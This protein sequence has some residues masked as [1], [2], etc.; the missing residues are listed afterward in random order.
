[1]VDGTVV[2]IENMVRH[3]SLKDSIRTPAERI[4]DAAHEVQRPVFYARG[5][6]IASYLPIFTLQAVEAASS[7][8]WPGPSPSR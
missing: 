5:I 1:V 3:L 4:R 7:S 6:I 2:M 8:P